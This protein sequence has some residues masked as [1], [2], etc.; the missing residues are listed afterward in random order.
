VYSAEDVVKKLAGNKTRTKAEERSNL[1]FDF[2][3]KYIHENKASREPGSLSVYR[4]LKNHLNEFQTSKK[5]KISFNNIDYSF[6][7]EFQNFLINIKSKRA[8]NGLGNVTIAKQLST[9][10]TFLNYARMHGIEVRTNYKDFKIK[11]ESLEVIALTNNEF[12][13]LY[14]LD[15]AG[16][17]RLDKVRDIFC[18]SCATG[19]RYSDLAQLKREHIKNDEI[20]MIITKTKQHQTIPLNP[21]SH[22]ILAKYSDLYRPLPIISNQ[23]INEY[24]K[25]LCQLAEITEPVQIVRFRGNKREEKLYPKH[26]LIS[27][28]TGRKTF[29][30]LSL[31][32]GMSAEE[33][34][35][36]SGH[37]DYKSFKRYVKITEQ[38]T[39]TVMR[40][41][42]GGISSP[43][44]KA[45]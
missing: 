14:A 26:E 24:L 28:H 39:K 25:E 36:I 31:E 38:R 30:T 7:S 22:S 13:T 9:L 2:I 12:E 23:K 32:K 42:W 6:F 41:A 15:L 35:Q 11:K 8:P 16:N 27:V 45:V 40:N 21:Y 17:K 44:L 37:R 3:D 5:K 34:M 19:L 20:K 43:K 18:F 33:V 29:C 4:S 10:K 1:I